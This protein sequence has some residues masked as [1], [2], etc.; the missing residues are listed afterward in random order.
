M[1]SGINS[2][3]DLPNPRELSHAFVTRTC[4]LNSQKTMAMAI[5]ATFIAHDMTHTAISTT[6]KIEITGAISNG[7][8]DKL[9]I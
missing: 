6:G 1:Y 7:G 9:T 4:S 5:W 8:W 3:K 2:I